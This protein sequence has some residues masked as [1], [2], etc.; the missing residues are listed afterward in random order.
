MFRVPSLAFAAA[1]AA[2]A[3]AEGG[4]EEGVRPE[5]AAP[6]AALVELSRSYYVLN[7]AGDLR[8]TQACFERWF[9]DRLRWTVRFLSR[10]CLGQ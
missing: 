4:G 5:A 2:A 10:A 1:A 7:P 6:A 9:A 3:G 8:D